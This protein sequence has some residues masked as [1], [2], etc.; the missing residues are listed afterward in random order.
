MAADTSVAGHGNGARR[1]DRGELRRVFGKQDAL[2]SGI[3]EAIRRL[4][5]TEIDSMTAYATQD[6]YQPT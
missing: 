5:W 1:T 3:G 6:A 4:S 2:C